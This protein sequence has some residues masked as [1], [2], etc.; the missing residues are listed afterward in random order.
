LALYSRYRLRKGKTIKV[1]LIHNPGA[2]DDSQSSGNHIRRLIRAAGHKVDYQS[3]REK[4]WTR[5][6]K[7]SSD[8]VAVAGGDGTVGK[9]AR[10]LMGTRRPIAILPM[11]TANNL[12]NMLGVTGADFENLILQWQ[13]A[14][15]VN[16]DAALAK[17]PWGS[18]P[19]IEGFG[20]G[21]FADA[22]FRIDVGK[23]AELAASK[24]PK[25]EIRSVLQMLNQ[26]L[27]DYSSKEL[28]VRLDG[29]DCSGDYI[30]LEAL[31]IRSIGPNLE[32]V[33]RAEFND[34]FLDVVF[35]TKDEKAKL[36]KYISDHM[37]GKV[38]SAN[39]TIRRARHL[40]V[41]WENYPV[42][43]DDKPWPDGKDQTA[44]RSHAVDV[45]IEPGALVFLVPG[46]KA[47]AAK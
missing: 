14:R 4:K 6:L 8:I 19:F 34:G 5:A 32:L 29:R 23:N 30:L 26:K 22:M 43:I 12:A 9:V 11:G 21:L 39:L 37:K 1:I 41:E 24:T 25:K 16:F 40:Q 35:I 17:G 7:E 45:K 31:N 46:K 18:Q 33:R 3:T 15:C 28:I 44:F 10:R 13:T 36:R 27:K 47:R 20:M 2:G 38:S 42:H